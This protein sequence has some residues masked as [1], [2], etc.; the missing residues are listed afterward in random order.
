VSILYADPSDLAKVVPRVVEFWPPGYAVFA[1]TLLGLTGSVRG[2]S[3]GVDLLGLVL[4]FTGWYLLGRRLI[5]FAFPAT[6]NPAVI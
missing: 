4:F 1:G 3:Y 5:P 6:V 2:A